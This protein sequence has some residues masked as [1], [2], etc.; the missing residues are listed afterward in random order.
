MNNA[1]GESHAR[2]GRNPSRARA[3]A[4]NGLDPG[5]LD[6]CYAGARHPTARLRRVPLVSVRASSTRSVAASR[7]RW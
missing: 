2:H 5:R 4:A 1:V 7:V 3:R 6:L